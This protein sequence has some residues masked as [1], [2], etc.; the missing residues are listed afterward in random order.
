MDELRPLIGLFYLYD[1]WPASENK[2]SLMTGVLLKNFYINL[3][4]HIQFEFKIHIRMR[5]KK[6]Y[7]EISSKIR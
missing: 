5:R 3:I 4:L 6:N 7:D 2:M 1:E